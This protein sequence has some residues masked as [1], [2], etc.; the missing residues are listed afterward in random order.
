MQHEE[1]K[2]DPAQL[3]AE[4]E[5]EPPRHGLSQYA[6]VITLLKQ[7]KGFSFREIAAWLQERGLSVDHNAVWRAYSRTVT[8]GT[9]GVPTERI[10]RSEREPAHGGAMPWVNEP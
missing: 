9:T 10:E 2:I 6:E 4:A 5:K 8:P 3:R 1:L 7:D